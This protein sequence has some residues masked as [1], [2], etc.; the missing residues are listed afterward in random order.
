MLLKK[1]IQNILV[2]DDDE[3]LLEAIK[4]KLESS[5]YHITTSNNVHDAYFKLNMQKPDLI[6]LDII[7]PD[8]N[9]IEFMSIINS[10]FLTSD[11][12]IIL[13]SYL[14]EKELYN[15][16]YSIGKAY[17]LAKPFNVNG[18]PQKLQHLLLST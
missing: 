6:M 18:L 8:M 10:Q 9:G 16:G 7:M 15:M 1:D 5:G 11:I 14:P 4:K 13:M 2:V 17:Y 3:F 12:P